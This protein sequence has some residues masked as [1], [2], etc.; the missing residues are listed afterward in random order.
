[1][2]MKKDITLFAQ[3]YKQEGENDLQR[4]WRTIK[5][6]KWYILGFVGLVT[7]L[8]LFHVFTTA[9]IYR[10]NTTVLIESQETKVLSIEEVYG[11]N[12][13]D[14]EYYQTQFEILRSRD[15]AERVVKHLA[16]TSHPLYDPS[17]AGQG[18]VASLMSMAG[19]PAAELTP[20]QT[21]EQVVDTVLMNLSIA[22]VRN[23]QLV[24]ISFESPDPKVAAEVTDTFATQYIKHHMEER[25][26]VTLK[27]TDWLSERLGDLR[28]TL[29][30]SE[31]NLQEYR[32]SEE[33]VDVQGVQT[34]GADEIEEVTQ[35]YVEAKQMRSQA[36]TT[37]EQ[38]KELGPNPPAYLL[39]AIPSIQS[40]DLVSAL[41][42]RKSIADSRVTEL[43]QRYGPKHPKIMSAVSE[44]SSAEDQLYQQIISVADGIKTNY[45]AALQTERALQRQL[46]TAKSS[47]QDINRKEIKLRELER[48]VE[49]NRKLFNMFL[50]RA[51]E[52]EEA[53]GLQA[54]HARVVDPAVTPQKPVKPN[55]SISLIV[56]VFLSSSFAIGVAIFK[57]STR[58]TVRTSDDVE[59]KLGTPLLGFLPKVSSNKSSST[60]RSFLGDPQSHFAESMRTV[61][62]SFVLSS[63][64]N[65]N[66]VVLVTSSVPD[67]GKSTVALNLAEALGRMEKVLLIDADLRRP[68]LSKVLELDHHLPGLAQLIGGKNSLKECVHEVESSSISV[69][70]TGNVQ[71]VNP[72]EIVSSKRISLL[73][74]QLGD[75]YDRIII[76]SPPIHAVSDAL[77][78]AA[79]A[80]SVMYVVKCDDTP[81]PVAAKGIKNLRAVGARI[82]GVV[83]NQVDVKKA[84]HYGG[85]ADHYFS[86]YGY[87][88]AEA[89]V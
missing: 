37:Y 70:S 80:D 35:R 19:E 11:L 82:T 9:P 17:Q 7:S 45:F 73:I 87:S 2:T 49:T 61:R 24:R 42:Q 46:A 62:T 16:L 63:M 44:A 47:L 15:L 21:L 12:T 32:E 34:L 57:E 69:I 56:A 71:G 33:L 60:Y 88:H 25:E 39:L 50:T 74:K 78:L 51:K 67:E 26:G 4:Y 41:S 48:E 55:K 30:E 3:T 10:A 54:A 89:K 5:L 79:Q 58:N 85:D 59:E 38:M 20:S 40:N 76:D 83:L 36:E 6:Y 1:M 77:V 28:N 81:A 31:Q 29:Q 23:T 65:N 86:D 53:R 52:T 72:L 66:K 75:K 43:S 14:Q 68:S 27:A 84:A 18:L 64:D 8:T 13:E 22:P